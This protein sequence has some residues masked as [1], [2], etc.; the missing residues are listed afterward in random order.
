MTTVGAWKTPGLEKRRIFEEKRRSRLDG[1]EISRFGLGGGPIN[2]VFYCIR[3]YQQDWYRSAD[4]ASWAPKR[5]RGGFKG[6][7]LCRRGLIF[8][9]GISGATE[10]VV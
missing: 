2:T 10:L 7:R 6:Y 9:E 5:R 4:H 3:E 8:D 1:A